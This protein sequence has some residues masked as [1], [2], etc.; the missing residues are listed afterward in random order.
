MVNKLNEAPIWVD[1][2]AVLADLCERW[3][4]QAAI[5]VDTEFM[6]TSTF[7]PI[8]GLIQIGDGY[9][10]Y[11][12]DPLAVSDV[13]PLAALMANPRVVK[14]FHA[15]SE[16][17]EVFARLLDCCPTPV[18]DTQIAAA[19]T[20]VGLSLGYAALLEQM[21]G[22]ALDKGETRSDW[23]Q[24]PLSVSQ[25]TYAALDVAHLLLIY[26]K[27]LA[28]L[29]DLG[30]LDWVLSDCAEL[31]GNYL[32]N[33]QPERFYL[34]I[35]NAWRLSAPELSVLKCLSLWREQVARNQDVPRNRVLKEA[36]LIAVAK[37]KPKH[38]AQLAAVDGMSASIAREH[39]DHL[40]Q[41]VADGL[42]QG[43]KTERLPGPLPKSLGD[44]LKDLKHIVQQTAEALD[45]PPSLLVSKKDYDYLM[46]SVQAG[47]QVQL[48]QRLLQWRK[49]LVGDA[50]L[51]CISA[52]RRND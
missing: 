21:L 50:L 29:K 1:S 51:D 33:Q 9:N 30:R 14:V 6:R 45:L 48:P 15:C 28:R 26:G 10:I 44:L 35:K 38:M 40:L 18:F 52:Y 11:L 37:A 34:R 23:L 7:Y 43:N 2:D 24:R 25:K 16:D 47:Q 41:L 5:A 4:Q 22:I 20:G 3:Q 19:Y 32:A 39:G 31:Q 8:A 17:M 42:A 13:G 36:V 27:L 46:R 49:A 12:I